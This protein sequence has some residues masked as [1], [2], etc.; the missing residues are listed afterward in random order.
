MQNKI[1]CGRCG[2]RYKTSYARRDEKDDSLSVC[3]KCNFRNPVPTS[4]EPSKEEEKSE[5]PPVR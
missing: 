5:L 1:N 2:I 4:P 3:P